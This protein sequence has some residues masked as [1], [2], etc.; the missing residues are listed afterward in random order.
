MR[1]RRVRPTNLSK[2]RCSRVGG[3][4]MQE[5]NRF[6]ARTG[7]G[8]LLTLIAAILVGPASRGAD[9]GK[10]ELKLRLKKGDV[11]RVG[12]TLDQS[13]SQTIQGQ[14]YDVKQT[15]GTGYVMTVDDLD[16]Q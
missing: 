4:T 1:R 15:M 16:L 3:A 14:K 2:R 5:R 8:I 12:L 13:I 9:D 7:F 6:T 10:V 11:Q